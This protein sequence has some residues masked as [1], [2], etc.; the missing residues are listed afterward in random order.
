[1][2]TVVWGDLQSVSPQRTVSKISFCIL[3]LLSGIVRPGCKP[4]ENVGPCSHTY[5]DPVLHIQSVINAQTGRSVQALNILQVFRNGQQETSLSLLSVSYN[6]TMIDST[7]LC[8]LPC[9][10]GTQAGTYS[11]AVAA[12]GCRDT[13][14]TFEANYAVFRGGCPSSNSGGTKVSFQMHSY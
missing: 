10:F 9:G 5:E 2:S 13:T 14:I 11:L 7:L 3:L 1:M 12:K 6:V 8:G 4:N